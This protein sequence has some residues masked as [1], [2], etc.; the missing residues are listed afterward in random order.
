MHIDEA[1]GRNQKGRALCPLHLGEGLFVGEGR[2]LEL[3]L[4]GDTVRGH[5]PVLSEGDI[6]LMP[7][8]S[9]PLGHE[10]LE[11]LA[12]I[13]AAGV[14]DVLEVL[15]GAKELR[16]RHKG[17]L[18]ILVGAE[19]ESHALTAG[20]L[21]HAEDGRKHGLIGIS[22][23][24]ITVEEEAEDVVVGVREGVVAVDEVEKQSGVSHG[25]VP[26]SFTVTRV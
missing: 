24:D 4:I 9:E 25:V 6:V 10:L 17:D 2:L 13:V 8:L 5:V 11:G 21:V 23:I 14:L 18:D 12:L 3:D 26:L 7:D 1:P 19:A 20:S 22:H 16:T 15:L